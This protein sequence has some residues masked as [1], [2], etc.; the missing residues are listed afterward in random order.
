M[1]VETRSDYYFIFIAIECF[2]KAL[3]SKTDPT[4]KSFME[5]LK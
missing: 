5:K 4:I 3:G 2:E 1:K